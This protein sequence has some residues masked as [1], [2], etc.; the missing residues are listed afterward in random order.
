MEEEKA[1]EILKYMELKNEE[2]EEDYKEHEE[3]EK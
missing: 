3:K 1:T 2:E